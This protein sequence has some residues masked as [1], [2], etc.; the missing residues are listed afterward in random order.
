MCLRHVKGLK[1]SLRDVKGLKWS[2]RDVSACYLFNVSRRE[3]IL[4]I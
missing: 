2:L 4:T 3:T 1:W